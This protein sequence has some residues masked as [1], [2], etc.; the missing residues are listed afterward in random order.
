[1]IS[2]VKHFQKQINEINFVKIDIVARKYFISASIHTIFFGYCWN[3][4]VGCMLICISCQFNCSSVLFIA[5][6]KYETIATYFF[7]EW[8]FGGWPKQKFWISVI[9]GDCCSVQETRVQMISSISRNYVCMPSNIKGFIE[10]TSWL[11]LFE[12]WLPMIT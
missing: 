2:N 3:V 9:C 12:N 10:V 8:N 6:S 7:T 11:F 1:M 5:V 4:F